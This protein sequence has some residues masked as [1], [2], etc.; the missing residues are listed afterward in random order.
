MEVL[1]ID[2]E[3]PFWCSFKEFGTVSSHLTYLFPPP[4]TIFGMLLNALGKPA[5]HTIDN[6]KAMKKLECEYFEA[7]SNLDF[8]ISLKE[9]GIKVDDYTCILKRN[10]GSDSIEQSLN[11]HL[12]SF[13]K[14]LLNKEQFEF[15]KSDKGYFFKRLSSYKV[16]S[17]N[18]ESDFDCRFNDNFCKTCNNPTLDC[19]LSILDS[20]SFF[21]DEMNISIIKEKIK[22][23]VQTYW[24]ANE[25]PLIKDWQQT[26]IIRQR[27]VKPKYTIYVKS[28]N[29]REYSLTSLLAA[30]KSPKRVLYLG[31][32]DDTIVVNAKIV[33]IN[34]IEITSDKI[35][36]IIPKVLGNSV[37]VNIPAMLRNQTS[38]IGRQICSIPNGKID[39][40]INCYNIEGENIV[41][42]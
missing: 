35:S 37:I 27:I 9:G 25:F 26:Q 17:R 14:K 38:E 10:R 24:D 8:A 3:I 39:K 29:D 15:L 16:M 30:L 21:K 40:E 42:L 36:S 18:I 1:K 34:D 13:V 6:D 23:F 28:S 33:E 41:F 32:S 2:L 19:V 12:K 7:F 5:L 22:K 31:E 4:P 11:K 20:E